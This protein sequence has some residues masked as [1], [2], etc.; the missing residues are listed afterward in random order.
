MRGMAGM[1]RRASGK[2]LEDPAT[3]WAVR[4]H[5]LPLGA[6]DLPQQGMGFETK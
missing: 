6:D 3:E 1:L 2:G 4:C 5:R